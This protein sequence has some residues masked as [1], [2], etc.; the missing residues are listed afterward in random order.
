MAK[1]KLSARQIPKLTEILRT[2]VIIPLTFTVFKYKCDHIGT[3]SS[4]DGD[5]YHVCLTGKEVEMQERFSNL[6]YDAQL[7]SKWPNQ[8]A[9]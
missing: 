9:S 3:S 8:D 1:L 4:V 6:V 7:V 5:C 2:T